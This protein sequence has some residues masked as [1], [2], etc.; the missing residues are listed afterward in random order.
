MNG[1]ACVKIQEKT[2]AQGLKEWLILIMMDAIPS[3]FPKISF[4]AVKLKN[5]LFI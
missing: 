3:A 5:I 2:V 4:P 1:N